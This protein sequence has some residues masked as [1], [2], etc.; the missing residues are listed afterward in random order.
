M[1]PII[2]TTLAAL[3]VAA[4]A[5]SPS[6]IQPVSM[7]NA[8]AGLSC[9]NARAMLAAERQKLMALNEAQNG[10][11]VGDALGVALIGVPVSSL[12][13]GDKAGDIATSKGKVVALEAR[14][15]RC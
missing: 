9:S 2:L 10:A 1:K 12:S 8:Y 7:G 14:L 13:G 11:V 4:C 3:S 15:T 6:A 5:Q